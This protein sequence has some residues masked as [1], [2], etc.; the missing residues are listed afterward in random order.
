MADPL[1][2]WRV[3]AE[4]LAALGLEFRDFDLPEARIARFRRHVAMYRFWCRRRAD[5]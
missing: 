2:G 5:G 4:G 3:F 1:A